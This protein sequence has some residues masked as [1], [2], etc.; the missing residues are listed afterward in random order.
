MGEARPGICA[1]QG[2]A[3]AQGK[4]GKMRYASQG[5]CERNGRKN[6]RGKEGL[7]RKGNQGR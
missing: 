5:T 6:A 1:R 7:I 4:P 3:D 2:R